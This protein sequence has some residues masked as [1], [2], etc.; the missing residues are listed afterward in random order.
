MCLAAGC[1]STDLSAP[2]AAPPSAD[3]DLGGDAD[4]TA[5]AGGWA[6]VEALPES[7]PP[8]FADGLSGWTEVGF[9]GSVVILGPRKDCRGASGG[10]TVGGEPISDASIFSIGS[11]TKTMTAVAVLQLVEAKRLSLDDSVGQWLDGLSAE[12]GEVTIAQLISHE[13]GLAN[14]HS[15]DFDPLTRDEAIDAIDALGLAFDPGSSELYSNSGYTLLAAIVEVVSGQ[16]FRQV[17]EDDVLTV[18]GEQLGWFWN[19]PVGDGQRAQGVLEGGELGRV[20]DFGGPHWAIEGAGGVAMSPSGLTRWASALLEGALLSPDLVDVLIESDGGA[21]GR[22]LAVGGGDET[23]QTVVLYVDPETGTSVALA[24]T[25]ASPN[26][27]DMIPVFLAPIE[28]G[29]P[30]PLPAQSY[31]ERV[32]TADVVGLYPV[33]VD[34]STIEVVAVRDGI[35][36]VPSGGAAMQLLFPIPRGFG[37]TVA[38][39][40]NLARAFAAGESEAGAEELELLRSDLGLAAD[41]EVTAT[42][43]GSGFITPD[44]RTYIEFE[45]GGETLLMW[46]SLDRAGGLN[47]IDFEQPLPARRLVATSPNQFVPA[48]SISGD[49]P[50]VATIADGELVVEQP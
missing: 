6:V 49:P 7:C 22:L 5:E 44:V 47:G 46:V 30:V 50:F 26:A 24:T 27:E 31:S 38:E 8:G 37:L 3:N 28:E 20:G 21:T 16:D 41:A 1:T 2:D 19:G 25:S 40:E 11:V 13:S 32:D 18:G 42:V 43:L 36:A 12:V 35:E 29:R 23:G 39:H 10:R 34:G 14:S 17:M 48:E 45:F 33:A 4:P 9:E 15:G